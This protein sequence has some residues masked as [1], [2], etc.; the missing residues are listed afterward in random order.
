M[1]LTAKSLEVSQKSSSY[2]TH[3]YLEATYID[4]WKIFKWKM[5]EKVPFLMARDCMMMIDLIPPQPHQALWSPWW[6]SSP[7]RKERLSSSALKES[8]VFWLIK[9]VHSLILN[10]IM[11][12]RR[13]EGRVDEKRG[14]E[15]WLASS[16]ALYSAPWDRKIKIST[17]MINPAYPSHSLSHKEDASHHWVISEWYQVHDTNRCSPQDRDIW[18]KLLLK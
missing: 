12:R 3:I 16:N 14:K 8:C 18:D 13:G 7:R 11:N 2:S 4:E 5:W 17:I 1:S 9:S 6:E 15:L 10:M